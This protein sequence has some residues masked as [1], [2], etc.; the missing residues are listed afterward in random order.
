MGEFDAL[1]EGTVGVDGATMNVAITNLDDIK[2]EFTNWNTQ[3]V[4]LRDLVVSDWLGGASDQFTSS[5]AQLADTMNRMIDCAMALRDYS[6]DSVNLYTAG[7]NAV[8]EEVAVALAI[9]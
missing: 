1:K 9:K 8:S 7:D 2:T 4:E 5:Y 6:Q 3:L